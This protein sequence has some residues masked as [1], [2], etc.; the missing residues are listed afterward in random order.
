[1]LASIL[2]NN[3]NYSKYLAYCVRSI[4]NQ[5][6]KNIDIIVYADGS[7]DNSLEILQKYLPKI[8]IISNKN[9]G[10]APSF[11]QG[12]AINK[13]F[14]ASKGDIIFL[15]DS[16]DAFLPE[17]VKSF[18]KSFQGD[19]KCVMVQHFLREIDEKNEPT[20]RIRCKVKNVDLMKHIYKTNNITGQLFGY[21]SSLAFKRSYLEKV[22]PL[23]IDE[24]EKM[25]PEV[26]LNRFAM[27][28]GKVITIRECLG[29]YRVH[30]SNDSDKLK[31]REY[32]ESFVTQ[33]Y[34]FF[35]KKAAEYGY[36]AVDRNKSV[37]RND[38]PLF[39]F[40]IF[41]VFSRERLCDKFI[42]AY[43]IIKRG[44]LKIR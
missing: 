20:G 17:K 9:F 35:N 8:K 14:E 10:H 42:Y 36:P 13:T 25:W 27:F 21:T 41:A 28:F 39:K 2:I 43:N 37:L 18:I 12:N 22:L 5:T 16:D 6:Y 30:G 32:F 7:T 44:L 4:L 38:L 26:R 11:N 40:L 1:M 29:E 33:L 15:L 3:Y 24:Y 34:E 31:N 23:E 19:D